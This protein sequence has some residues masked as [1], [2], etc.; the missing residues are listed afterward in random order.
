MQISVIGCGRW[1]SFLAWYL[2]GIGHQITL[3]G[4][5][6]SR[7]FTELRKTGTNGLVTLDEKMNLT[8]DLG[9]ALK[10]QILVISIG[11]QSFRSLMEQLSSRDLAG[12]TVVL[13]MKGLEAGTGK[14]LTQIFEEYR[15]DTPVAVWVGPGHVQDFTR[16]IPNC[17]VIDSRSMQVKKELVNAFSS[18]LIRFY[19]GDDLIG[20]EIGAASKN[21]IGI[22]AGMLDGLNKTA[23]KGA[24]MSRGTREIARLIRKMGGNEITAYGLAHLGD[25]E[26]TVFSPYSHNRRFGEAFVRG[27][28]YGELAEGV[29]T[30]KAMLTLGRQYQ[31]EL[32]ISDA[33]NRVINQGEEPNR[34]LSDLFLRSIK[35]EF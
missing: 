33:V 7:K 8:S 20:N 29:A 19:Y 6:S 25:Y 24:L 18:D 16:G 10:S 23:L 2:N 1:G 5:E 3:Y 32:P 11:A 17:M 12:K 30:T 26:A 31:A 21:V 13:C 9:A 35:M 15:P 28:D 27:E 14:R 4:R 22:A 34:V